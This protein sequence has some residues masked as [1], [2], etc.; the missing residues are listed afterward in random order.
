MDAA[1][2]DADPMRQVRRWLDEARAGGEPFPDEMAVATATP[3]GVPSARMVIP[4]GYDDGLV[5]FTDFTSQ[6]GRELTANP[7]AAAILHWHAPVHR[8]VRV[9]GPVTPVTDAEAD[10]Y[11]D[12]RPPGSRRSAVSSHQSTVVA[13]RAR[14]EET[15]RDVAAQYPDDSAVPRPE[16]WSGFRI[17]PLTVEFWEE[18]RDRL[19]DRIRYRADAG[20]SGW[21]V[22][23]LSP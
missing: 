17:T 11:W 19:H 9:S 13:S 22:E 14:L 20:G 3:E 4:R 8:Q 23:R 1:D 5:F 18:G 15:A 6:K 2:L 10:R 7:V 12:T 16:R 21:I